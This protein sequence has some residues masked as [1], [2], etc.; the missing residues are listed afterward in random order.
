DASAEMA[1]SKGA[2]M[3]RTPNRSGPAAAR[4][5]AAGS[6]AGEILMFVDADVLIEVD[7]LSKVASRFVHIPEISALFGSYDDE[8]A[9]QN[10]LSQY[11]N[12]QHHFVHQTSSRNASTF[13]S[14]LGAIRRDVFLQHGGFDCDKFPEPSIE[15]IELGFR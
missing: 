9:E 13:W 15:D 12:L 3:L 5:L 2:R 4:N 7:T 14:G 11:K 6:S 8:P 10:F 1:R